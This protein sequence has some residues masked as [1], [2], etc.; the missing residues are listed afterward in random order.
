MRYCCFCLATLLLIAAPATGQVRPKDG[1]LSCF[2]HRTGAWKPVGE[3][4]D[5]LSYGITAAQARMVL[6]KVHAFTA[7]VKAAPVFNPPLGF[8]AEVWEDV[9]CAG[10]CQRARTCKTQPVPGRLWLRMHYFVAGTNGKSYTDNELYADMQV[11]FNSQYMMLN[12]DP[13]LRFPDG[14]E[15]ARMPEPWREING[16]TFYINN[17]NRGNRFAFLTKGRE[18]LWIPV[19]REQFLTELIREREADLAK[20]FKGSNDLVEKGRALTR[21]M[22]IDPLKAE[23]DRMSPSERASQAWYGGGM[24]SQPLVPA[25]SKRGRPVVVFNPKYFDASRPRTDL[26]LAVISIDVPWEH[27]PEDLASAVSRGDIEHASDVG[28]AR[29]WELVNQLDWQQLKGLIK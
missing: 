20:D 6:A 21:K 28:E 7:I 2:P 9:C 15:A 19:S 18:P 22:L 25:N 5:A 8:N 16:V 24:P 10:E 3:S 11:W 27:E 4:A 12:G 13:L 23:I 17:D 29:M 14:R 26:Q 1:E